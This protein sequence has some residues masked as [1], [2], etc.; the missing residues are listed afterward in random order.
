[1]VEVGAYLVADPESFELV[2]PGEGPLD[3]PSGLAESG[4]MCSAFSGDLRCDAA[5]PEK[6]AVRVVVVAAVGEQSARPVSG[7]PRTPRMRG[8]A[9]SRGIS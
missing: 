7:R 4:S 1:V 8:I 9:S 5:G 3:D 2:E 6:A